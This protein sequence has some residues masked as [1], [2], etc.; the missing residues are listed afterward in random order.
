M[1]R[2]ERP[3]ANTR[4][5]CPRSGRRRDGGLVPEGKLDRPCPQKPA[6]CEP[7]TTSAG[8]VADSRPRRGRRGFLFRQ[9]G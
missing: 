5:R 3:R 4:A 2:S 6:R 8:P 7:A 1:T 9:P